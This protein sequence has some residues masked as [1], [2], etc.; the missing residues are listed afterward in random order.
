MNRH[1]DSKD[2]GQTQDLADLPLTAEDAEEARAGS[3]TLN[4]YPGFLGGVRVA[5]R[6][7]D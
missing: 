1:D 3:Q 5:A 4:S 6:D 7:L 2:K